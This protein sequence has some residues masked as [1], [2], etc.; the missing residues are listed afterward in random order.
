MARG[1]LLE[2]WLSGARPMDRATVSIDPELNITITL[3]RCPTFRR[4]VLEKVA[5]TETG[6]ALVQ[7]LNARDDVLTV[8]KA[9]L[10]SLGPLTESRARN[11]IGSA[12]SMMR[13]RA[14]KID[15]ETVDGFVT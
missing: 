1:Q 11:D 10:A 6:K 12:R 3:A 8:E 13:F 2:V 5:L 7:E 9:Y 15:V 4:A 14:V